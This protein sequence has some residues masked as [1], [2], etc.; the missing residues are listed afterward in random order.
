MILYYIILYGIDRSAV[1][2]SLFW[3]RNLFTLQGHGDSSFGA[4]G[5]RGPMNAWSTGWRAGWSTRE[6]PEIT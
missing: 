6:G 1:F 4:P 3:T 5:M 2:M